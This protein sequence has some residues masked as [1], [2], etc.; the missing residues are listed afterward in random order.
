MV[1]RDAGPCYL[2]RMPRPS[3][4]LPPLAARHTLDEG[5]LP[6]HHIRVLAHPHEAWL[7][8]IEDLRAAQVSILV[9]LYTLMHDRVGGQF[10][11]ELSE[12]VQRGVDVRIELDAM[13]SLNLPPAMVERMTQAGIQWRLYH[14]VLAGTPF[15]H[16][17]RRNHRKLVVID[18][19][20]A[21]VSGRNMGEPYYAI[22]PEDVAWLDLG[23]RV[24]GPCVETIAAVAR[25]GWKKVARPREMPGKWREKTLAV[26]AFNAGSLRKAFAIRRILVA[27]RSAQTSIRMVQAYFLPDWAM[28][29]ALRGA[30][31]RHVDVRIIVPDMATTDQPLV[32]LAS[33]H[34]VGQLLRHGV[35]VFYVREGTLHGKYTVVD[36]KWWTVG[37]ANLDPFSRQHNLEANIAGLGHTQ[38]QQIL[39][40]FDACVRSCRELT[41][42]QWQQRPWWR[43][44]A[45]AILWRLRGVV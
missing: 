5:M 10:L 2:L 40:N 34:G 41:W 37:S 31:R 24:Q 9:E 11:Q 12:A 28:A 6:G 8:L 26:A 45:G 13:G 3:N 35:R 22:E 4:P 39:A 23:V 20:V 21:H 19:Q 29:R 16:W 17:F 44:F 33:E 15:R 18:E 25:S 1:L 43:K 27:V 42:E 36:G 32:A 30:A 7:C 14:P 38:A